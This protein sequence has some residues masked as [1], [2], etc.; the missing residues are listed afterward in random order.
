MNSSIRPLSSSSAIPKHPIAADEIPPQ[1][2]ATTYPAEFAA[3]VHG[4]IKRRLAPHFGLANY[5]VNLTTLAPG[6]SSAL[7][8]SHTT[9]DEFVYIL[10]GCPTLC[11]G[12][13]KI[14][15]TAGQCMGF[16]K[17]Q[18]IGHCLVNESTEVVV[19][20]EVGDRSPNDV[21]DYPMVDLMAHMNEEGKYVFQHKD[22]TP[23][24]T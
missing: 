18:N 10:Q 14:P 13:D 4:R 15:M 7:Q 19:Y 1:S 8:H 21:V 9:Q 5:G 11:L 20:L 16:P 23:Y 22:G 24:D 17:N 6:A 3:T 12:H 2:H